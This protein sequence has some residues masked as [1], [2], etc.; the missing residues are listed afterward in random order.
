MVTLMPDTRATW[1]SISQLS[2]SAEKDALM[3]QLCGFIQHLAG[4][5]VGVRCTTAVAA[6]PQRRAGEGSPEWLKWDPG[7]EDHSGKAVSRR[8]FARA[9]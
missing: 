7:E 3:K 5:G 2:D 8:E 9:W 6:D 1:E 4:V